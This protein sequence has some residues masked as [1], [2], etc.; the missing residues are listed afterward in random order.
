M[1]KFAA[2]FL[3]LVMLLSVMS[4]T[5]LADEPVTLRVYDWSDSTL[6]YRE[7]FHKEFMEKNPDIIV[8]YTQ[9]TI[10]QF[11]STVVNAIQS[12]DGPDLFP[13]PTTLNLT[14]AVNEG[15]FLDMEQYVSKEFV[16][17][18]TDGLLAEGVQRKNGVLYTVPEAGAISNS[19]IFYNKDILAE[20]GLE[21]PATFEEF[22]E[23]CK[24][25]TKKGAGNYYGLIEGGN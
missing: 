7:Q 3:S 15:W 24:V 14:T 6:A 4:L 1:K 23:A 16:N 10:D 18:F 20:C 11:N 22:R 2:L 25:I 9:L 13:V 8:E 17:S 12:G 21:V 5:A 19:M